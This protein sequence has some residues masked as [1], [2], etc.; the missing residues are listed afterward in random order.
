MTPKETIDYIITSRRFPKTFDDY[1]NYFFLI[2]PIAFVAIGFSMTYNF[3]KF[4]SGAPILIISAI[5]I[6][7]GIFFAFFILKRLND[8]ITF[9]SITTITDDNL[10]NVAEKRF[11]MGRAINLD[12]SQRLYFSE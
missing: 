8:N 11:F 12:I 5:F 10:D 4:H 7:F 6:S 3:I 2:A 9:K 1:S